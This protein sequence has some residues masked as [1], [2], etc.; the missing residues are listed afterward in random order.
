MNN[1][2][3]SESGYLLKLIDNLLKHLIR[4][5]VS[6]GD[7]EEELPYLVGNIFK[8]T[9]M[10]SW[11]LAFYSIRSITPLITLTKLSLLN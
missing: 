2:V 3:A 1:R 7:G 6:L 11:G 9:L 10:E 5:L 8:K 4:R